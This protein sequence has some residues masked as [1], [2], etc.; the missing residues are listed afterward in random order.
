M[1]GSRDS[2]SWLERHWY[3]VVIAFGVAFVMLLNFF[4][5]TW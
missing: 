2:Q 1:S 5:P 3:W 4:H